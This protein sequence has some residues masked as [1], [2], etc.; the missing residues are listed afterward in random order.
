MLLR[1]VQADS[2]RKPYG[3]VRPRPPPVFFALGKIS[4]GA[5]VVFPTAAPSATRSKVAGLRSRVQ[6]FLHVP[7]S[8]GRVFA[9]HVR[10]VPVPM[11]L[12]PPDIQGPSAVRAWLVPRPYY[13]S[14]S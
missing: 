9:L 5:E 12:C 7:S 3:L 13:R 2:R 1:S 14:A 6:Y 11:S 10:T 8:N 4:P